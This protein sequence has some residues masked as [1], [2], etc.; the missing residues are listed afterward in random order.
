MK[1]KGSLRSAVAWVPAVV[2][3][4]VIFY[5]SSLSEPMPVMKDKPYEE[6]VNILSHMAEYAGLS[7]WFYF[8][9]MNGKPFQ[10][11]LSMRSLAYAVF[12]SLLYAFSDEIHQIFVPRR[13]FAVVDLMMDA[14]GSFIAVLMIWLFKRGCLEV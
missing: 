4:G 6:L 10:A 5:Y 12:A 14:V 7:F 13:M 1:L 3:M 9:R 11:N 8:G 2:W